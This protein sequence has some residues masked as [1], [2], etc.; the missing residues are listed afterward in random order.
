MSAALRR[1]GQAGGQGSEKEEEKEKEKENKSGSADS[2][3]PY[4]PLAAGYAQAVVPPAYGTRS[5]PRP[6]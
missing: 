1:G 6:E 3:A 5:A 2:P 4:L